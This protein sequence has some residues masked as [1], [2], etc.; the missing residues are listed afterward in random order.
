MTLLL[1]AIIMMAFASVY[2]GLLSMLRNRADAIVT[3]L[4]GG[5]PQAGGTAFAA[6]RRF[7]RA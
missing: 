1:T 4:F 3:A 5:R 7:S 2:A 6:S